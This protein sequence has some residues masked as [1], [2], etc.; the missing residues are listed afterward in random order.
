MNHLIITE[1]PFEMPTNSEDLQKAVDPH[2]RA[3]NAVTK[4]NGHFVSS[5]HVA[6]YQNRKFLFEVVKSNDRVEFPVL[7]N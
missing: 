2:I 6:T 4:N 7:G 3:I 1:I 5:P